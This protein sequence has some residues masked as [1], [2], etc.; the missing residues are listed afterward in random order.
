MKRPTDHYAEHGKQIP[1]TMRTFRL[2]K[3]SRLRT[4]QVKWHVH[5]IDYDKKHKAEHKNKQGT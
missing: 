1:S 5:S 4:E 2:R 3:Q